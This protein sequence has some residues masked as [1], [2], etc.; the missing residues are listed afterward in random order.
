MRNTFKVYVKHPEY[1]AMLCEKKE[2]K[3]LAKKHQ[4]VHSV[5][6]DMAR[7][8]SLSLNFLNIN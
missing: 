8:L 4:P 3:A 2:L 5:Q 1:E 6:S 7:Y